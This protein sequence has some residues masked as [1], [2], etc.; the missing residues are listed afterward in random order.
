M[1]AFL[2]SSASYSSYLLA[3]LHQTP[4]QCPP[5]H[6]PQH[7]FVQLHP[8]A[9][10]TMCSPYHQPGFGKCWCIN[11]GHISK[12]IFTTLSQCSQLYSYPLVLLTMPSQCSPIPTLSMGLLMTWHPPLNTAPSASPPNSTLQC[13]TT[14]GTSSSFRIPPPS[15]TSLSRRL[16]LTLMCQQQSC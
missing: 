2:S 10:P 5:S 4:P 13:I 9:L 11:S 15:S 6:Y 8:S 7:F 16:W 14:S 3:L 1:I 12:L